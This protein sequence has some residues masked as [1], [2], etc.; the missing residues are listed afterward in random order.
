MPWMMDQVDNVA[1]GHASFFGN[2]SAS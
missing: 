1:R 2:S